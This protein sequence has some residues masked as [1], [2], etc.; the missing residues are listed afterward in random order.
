MIRWPETIAAGKVTDEMFCALDWYSTLAHL[1]GE[2]RRIPK[3]RPYDSINQTDFL[4]GRQKKLNREYVVTYVGDQVFAVKWM[5]LKVH[6]LTAGPTFAPIVQ[7][8]FPQVY[9]IKNDPDEKAELWKTQ[10]YAHL[11]V[12]KPVMEILAGLKKSMRKYPNIKPG[13]DFAGYR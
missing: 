3:D 13:Q 4:L 1:I 11:W 9:D 6:F 7:H 10:G 8:T 12:M 5:S 2:D